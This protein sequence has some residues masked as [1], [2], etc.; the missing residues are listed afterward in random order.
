MIAV[1]VPVYNTEK[2]LARCID[3]VR[4]QTFRDFV[5]VLVDDGSTDDCP[6]ICDRF[7]RLDSK[8]HVIHQENRGLSAARN[9]GIEWV[10]THSDSQYL[11]FIDSDDWVHPQYL[12]RLYLAI[13]A[14]GCGTAVCSF[15]KTSEETE[16]N[17]EEASGIRIVSPSD[18]YCENIANFIVAWG[19]LYRKTDFTELRFP[20]GKVHE[21]EFTTWKVLFKYDRIAV[22]DTPLYAY[23]QREDSIIN[24]TWKIERLV[25]LEAMEEQRAWI[26]RNGDERLKQRVRQR[27]AVDCAK[28]ILGMKSIGAD[29]QLVSGYIKK[30]KDYI[31]DA[32]PAFPSGKYYFAYRV[33]WPHWSRVVIRPLNIVR[34]GI[35][36]ISR[37]YTI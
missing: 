10:L 16:F 12:E 8:V 23:F 9:A 36:V 31:R 30:L 25:C 21:D 35:T 13:Q 29:K 18:Y 24:S 4:A 26:D 5:L 14:D 11:T 3:S 2:L 33:A 32:K 6:A 34:K 37:K 20:E 28:L 27:L 15:V 1:I 7:E 17:S 22:I 19:K